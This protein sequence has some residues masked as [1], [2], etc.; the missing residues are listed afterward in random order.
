MLSV[1]L[2]E[3]VTDVPETVD[4]AVGAVTETTGAV[5]SVLLTVT[6]TP[7][8][9]VR[10]LEV[11]RALAVMVCAPFEAEVLSQVIP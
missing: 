3:T 4:P 10:L 8:D 9:V 5:E 11:S 2:A 1:A 6:L 7:A